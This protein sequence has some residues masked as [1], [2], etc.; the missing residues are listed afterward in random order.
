MT[1]QVT[2]MSD[3]QQTLA[4]ILYSQR[5]ALSSGAT[6]ITILQRSKNAKAA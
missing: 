1:K 2:D 3:H 4:L 5:W 6:V